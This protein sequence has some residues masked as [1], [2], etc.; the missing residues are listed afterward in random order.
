MPYVYNPDVKG[1]VIAGI[2]NEKLVFNKRGFAECPE[3]KLLN[4]FASIPPYKVLAELPELAGKVPAFVPYNGVDID[5][6]EEA[7]IDAQ[8][9]AAISGYTLPVAT[10]SA[11]DVTA[12]APQSEAPTTQKVKAPRAT[13]NG[14]KSVNS[15]GY[16]RE[17]LE[18]LDSELPLFDICAEMGL[19]VENPRATK[20]ELIELIMSN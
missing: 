12:D 7:A 20:A 18:A 19:D 9:Q 16:T 8:I 14:K 11:E 1:E 15:K 10:T 13:G 4:H 5:E 6:D 3:G 2:G 17:Q